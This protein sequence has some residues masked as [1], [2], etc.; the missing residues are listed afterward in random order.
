MPQLNK[1]NSCNNGRGAILEDF[2]KDILGNIGFAIQNHNV[3]QGGC[4]VTAS[5][6]TLKVNGQCWNWYGGYPHPK[7]WRSTINQLNGQINILFSFGVKPTS[8]QYNEAKSKHIH[9]IHYPKQLDIFD[10]EKPSTINWLKNRILEVLS[11]EG[12]ITNN[13]SI[14]SSVNQV[15]YSYSRSVLELKSNGFASWFKALVCKFKGKQAKSVDKGQD[16][17]QVNNDCMDKKND[18]MDEYVPI[19]EA[20]ELADQVSNKSECFICHKKGNRSKFASLAFCDNCI[21]ETSVKVLDDKG[22]INHN[23]TQPRELKRREDYVR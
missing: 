1:G 21:I 20:Y 19:S 4:D 10:D 17:P 9:I 8:Q 23:S 18:S 3:W 2:T 12:V 13:T 15:S 14:D 7:R 16:S 5:L 11:L 22:L 6:G